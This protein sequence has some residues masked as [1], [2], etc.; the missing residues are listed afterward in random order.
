[1]EYATIPIQLR[2]SCHLWQ[3]WLVPFERNPRFSGRDFE[4][5]DLE[6]MIFSKGSMSK[7]VAITGLGGVGKTQVALE[8]AYQVRDKH[9]QCSV[10]WITSTSLESIE[11]GYVEMG[12]QL[13]VQDA[14]SADV[15]ST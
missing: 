2:I 9:P 8:L 13:E 12:E 14:T 11:Q 15:K 10:F 4:L 5:K 7:T 6:K 3:G 1:V